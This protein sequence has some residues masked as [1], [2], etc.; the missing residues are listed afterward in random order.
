[1]ETNLELARESAQ[2]ARRLRTL[3]P[4][5]RSERD[6]EPSRDAPRRPGRGGVGVGGGVG[7]LELGKE[8]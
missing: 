4:K 7:A 6:E 8:A 5:W 3:K 1:M 2:A